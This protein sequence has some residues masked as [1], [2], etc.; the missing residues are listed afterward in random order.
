MKTSFNLRWLS[1]ALVALTALASGCGDEGAAKHQVVFVGT[2]YNVATGQPIDPATLTMS[3]IVGTKSRDCRF[4]ETGRFSCPKIN[5]Y[6]DYSIVVAAAGFRPF[7][8]HNRAE[9]VPIDTFQ[10]DGVLSRGTFRNIFYTA[11]LAPDN[12]V[13]PEATITVSAEGTQP[14]GKAR[15]IPT[16]LSSLEE[17][18]A[19]L[20]GV[21]AQ[22]WLNDEDFLG[23][24]QVFDVTAG[25]LVIPAGALLVGVPYTITVYEV[26]GFAPT[27]ADF[28]LTAGP[29]TIG[30]TGLAKP[31]VSCTSAPNTAVGSGA[32]DITCNQPVVLTPFIAATVEAAIEEDFETN[33][34][35][36]GGGNPVQ[37][38]TVNTSVTVAGAVIQLRWTNNATDWPGGSFPATPPTSVTWGLDGVLVA[39]ANDPSNTSLLDQALT[40]TPVGGGVQVQL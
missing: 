18:E 29:F 4:D 3:I 19:L 10:V 27:S 31:P 1:V 17:E 15:V 12:L 28:D 26:E 33:G 2:V 39:P 21:G 16:A 5:A 38:T 11:Y 23:S 7:I 37:P 25:Q 34:A 14:A 36:D 30:L 35:Q 20:P 13:G 24:R 8:S 6:D 40:P 9:G 22:V 32:L